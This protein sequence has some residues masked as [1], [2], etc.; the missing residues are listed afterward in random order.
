MLGGEK[1]GGT[2]SPPCGIALLSPTK[3]WKKYLIKGEN[4]I[5]KILKQKTSGKIT[6]EKHK[7][8]VIPSSIKRNQNSGRKKNLLNRGKD[9]NRWSLKL[10]SQ[11]TKTE[12]WESLCHYNSEQVC[13]FIVFISVVS[14]L[15]LLRLHLEIVSSP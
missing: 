5:K 14:V 7:C 9:Y 6:K 15:Q 4:N 13:N 1:F 12:N 2:V 3:F 8:K 11:R 10:K